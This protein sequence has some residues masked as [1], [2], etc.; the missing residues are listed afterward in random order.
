MAKTF[1]LLMCVAT[2]LT[3]FSTRF[4]SRQDMHAYHAATEYLSNFKC[5][6]GKRWLQNRRCTAL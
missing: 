1:H 2:C 5:S 4:V 6:Q 3:L